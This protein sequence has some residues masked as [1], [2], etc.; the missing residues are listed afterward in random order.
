MGGTFALAALHI[1]HR[2]RIGEPACGAELD[3]Q[4]DQL[5]HCE[6]SSHNYDSEPVPRLR[7]VA[8]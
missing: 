3:Y 2:R 8:H 1:I 7:Q 5:Q 6:R 4:H